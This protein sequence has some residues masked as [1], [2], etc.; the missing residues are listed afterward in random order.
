MTETR[1]PTTLARQIRFVERSIRLRK[2][3]LGA[4]KHEAEQCADT[5]ALLEDMLD[6][7]KSARAVMT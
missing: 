1:K 7:L 6:T 5:L 3:K 4:L 2:M